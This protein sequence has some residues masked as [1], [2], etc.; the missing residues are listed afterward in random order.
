[1]PNIHAYISHDQLV[2]N[3]LLKKRKEKTIDTGNAKYVI[4]LHISDT[5]IEYC[6]QKK[7]KKKTCIEHQWSLI[8]KWTF[9][10]LLIYM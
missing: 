2:L 7:K 5:C 1:M 10:Y 9:I 3:I 6:S 4:C 8:G